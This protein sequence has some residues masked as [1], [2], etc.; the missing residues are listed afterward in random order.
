VSKTRISGQTAS[1]TG[2]Q[3]KGS[4]RLTLTGPLAQKDNC[5]ADHHKTPIVTIL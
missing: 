4:G 3:K 5:S 1:F 2:F